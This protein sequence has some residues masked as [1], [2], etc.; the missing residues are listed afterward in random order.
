MG[1]KQIP[2][3]QLETNPRKTLSECCDSGQALVVEMPD[4]RLVAIQTLE[5]D[6]DDGLI[7]ELIESNASFRDLLQKSKSSPRK[8]FPGG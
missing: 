4:H 5:P 1:I 2:L 3:S 8:L 6:G 7:D